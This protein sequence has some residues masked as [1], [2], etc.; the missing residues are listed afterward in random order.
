M[1]AKSTKSEP[2]LKHHF[3]QDRQT[4]TENFWEHFSLAPHFSRYT[5]PNH[6]LAGSSDDSKIQPKVSEN[7]AT[8]STCLP[9]PTRG[10][11]KARW[12]L[13]FH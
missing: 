9:N 4:Q 5:K 10:V 11:L 12:G 1:I 8:L 6:E 2:E 7:L 3:H 13:H